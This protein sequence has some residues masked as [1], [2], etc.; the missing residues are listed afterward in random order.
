MN[1]NNQNKSYKVNSLVGSE[2]KQIVTVAPDPEALINIKKEVEK[3]EHD[4]EIYRKIPEISIKLTHEKDWIKQGESWY[5]MDCGSEK[6]AIAWG[7]DLAIIGDLTREDLH[8]AKGDY[9]IYTAKGRAR[10]SKFGRYL[11]DIGTCSQRDK[12]FGM[13][14]GNLKEVEDI[15]INMIKKKA[16]TNCYNRLIKRLC[17]LLSVTE[18]QIKAAGLDISKMQKVVF[19]SGSKKAAV[20]LNKSAKEKRDEI[21]KW[22]LA[23]GNGVEKDAK[24]VLGQ[25]SYYKKGDTEFKVTDI[26]K[27]TSARWIDVVHQKTKLRYEEYC[28]PTGTKEAEQQEKSETKQNNK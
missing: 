15:D 7:V 16:V 14:G 13:A 28:G 1:Q 6:I 25:I 24:F 11:E 8:D 10:S 27:L 5:L 21:W 18:D 26:T 2:D 19:Q 4:I 23:L 9:Y 3:V 12:F 22:C 20:A 17:G